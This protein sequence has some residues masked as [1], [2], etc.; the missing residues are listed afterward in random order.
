MSNTFTLFAKA[1]DVSITDFVAEFKQLRH[2]INGILI[3][4][5][6]LITLIGCTPNQFEV[7]LNQFVN[8]RMHNLHYKDAVPIH[9]W[10]FSSLFLD[11]LSTLK[12]EINYI[13]NWCHAY[14]I[15]IVLY[16]AVSLHYLIDDLRFFT[17]RLISIT[18]TNLFQNAIIEDYNI[19][20]I[21]LLDNKSIAVSDVKTFKSIIFYKQIYNYLHSVRNINLTH[22]D[23]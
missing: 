10:A 7:Y 20:N 19:F 5:D 4:V 3:S 17:N 23:I 21:V 6:D 8:T 1:P 12:L 15:H 22:I 14:D 16:D 2:A 13:L 18:D 11:Y 9:S